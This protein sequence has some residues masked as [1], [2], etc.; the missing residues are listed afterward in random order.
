MM[1]RGLMVLSLIFSVAAHGQIAIKGKVIDSET[2]EVIIG[3]NIVQKSTINGATTDLNGAFEIKAEGEL[4]VTLLVNYIG[5]QAQ[6][7][8]VYDSGEPVTVNMVIN[9]N[10]LNEVVV[11]GYVQQKRS[12]ITAS[13]SS[14]KSESIADIQASSFDAKLQGK[15]PGL[16]VSSNSGSPGTSVALRIRGTTSINAGNEPLYV[17]DGVFINNG[18]LQR[19]GN[20]GQET[21]ALTD[22]NPNDIE[23]IE[24]L[25]DA[26]ATSIYG[27]RGANGVILITTKRG[28]LNSK[29]KVSAGAQYGW[30]KVKKLWDM[31]DGPEYAELTNEIHLNDGGSADDLPYPNPQDEP[32]YLDDKLNAIFKTALQENYYLNFS[33]G[34][35]K[36]TYYLGLDYNHQ[37]GTNRPDDFKRYSVRINLDNKVS[38]KFTVGTSNALS[39]V[40][41]RIALSANNT[42]APIPSAIHPPANVPSYY[43]DGSYLAWGIHDSY[44]AMMNDLDNTSSS[45]R[46]IS[47]VYGEYEILKNLVLRSSWNIDYN[48]YDENI[49]YPSVTA[50]AAAKKGEA[51]SAYTKRQTLINE[52]TLRYNTSIAN[53]HSLS[54][55]VGNTIQKNTY[56]TRLITANGFPSDDFKEIQFSSIQTASGGSRESG[57]L[58]FFG[59]AAYDYESKYIADLNIRADGSSRFGS[60]NRWGVFPSI[61]AAWNVNRERWFEAS[62]IDDFKIR[63]NYGLTGNQSGIG[64]YDSVELWQGGSNYNSESGITPVQLANPNLKWETTSQFNVG[65][66]AG[67]FKNRLQLEFNYYNKYTRDLLV[68]VPI[69]AISG[70]SGLS[71]NGGEMSN[72]GVELGISSVNITNKSFEW[73]SSFNI[74]HNKN[75]IEKLESPVEQYSWIRMEEGHPMFS[76]YVYKQLYVDPETGDAVF[77]DYNKD[78]KINAD[79]RQFVGN[80]LPVVSGG[81]DNTFKYKNFDLNLFMSYSLGNDVVYMFQYMLQHGGTRPSWG[82]TKEQLGRW[83]QPGDITDIPRLTKTGTNYSLRT[84]RFIEDGSFLKLR[85]V[86]L[87]YNIPS[88]LT[89]RYGIGGLRIYATATNLYTLTNYSGLDPEINVAGDDANVLGIDFVTAP[90]PRSFLFGFNITL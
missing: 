39:R 78:G 65:L 34:D 74:A 56:A 82:Y 49:Y 16:V 25:K 79:D 30:A 17:V 77:D 71:K 26:N 9:Y 68:K 89:K 43:P 2:K 23:N 8:E 45:N 58:S 88:S 14:L 50:Y 81:L 41:R 29:T 10:F 80:A 76:F 40:D 64:D 4:P 19:I 85:T 44:L 37:E 70:F 52:Q 61:G 32:S 48:T 1:K 24:V 21:N 75:K 67:F 31:A 51:R 35:M 73:R 5:Y 60:E 6:E 90:S 27:A 38:D 3:A 47:S 72:K 59:R 11:T 15:I 22:L 83:R 57:L 28:K 84:S 62:W 20:G 46:I 36:T 7:I 55:L 63:T 54:F 86:T 13:V 42:A 87:G 12:V 18:S 33:G 69:V 53:K 66:D